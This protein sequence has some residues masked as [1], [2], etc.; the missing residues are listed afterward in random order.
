MVLEVILN[1][2]VVS[3]QSR[4]FLR[5]VN[6]HGNHFPIFCQEAFCNSRQIFSTWALV[7]PKEP[8][9]FTT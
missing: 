6:S 5:Q 7:S 9:L 4:V 3:G 8:R 1:S 2:F